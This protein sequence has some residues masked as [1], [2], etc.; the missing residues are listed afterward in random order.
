MHKSSLLYI[1]YI[2]IAFTSRKTLQNS[3][4]YL[5]FF[6]YICITITPQPSSGLHKT[7]NKKT[8]GRY[9]TT[10]DFGQN[11]ETKKQYDSK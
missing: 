3:Y 1:L 4:Y 5:I 10:N 6:N 7:E 8:F 9:K 2:G 11:K